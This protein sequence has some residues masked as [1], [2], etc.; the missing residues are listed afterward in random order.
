MKSESQDNDA[1]SNPLLNS[2]GSNVLAERKK[3]GSLDGE[4]LAS[5]STV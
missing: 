4:A 2:S 3:F 5:S 1:V